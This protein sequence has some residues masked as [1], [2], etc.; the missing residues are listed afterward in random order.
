MDTLSFVDAVPSVA[1]APLS[2]TVSPAALVS[3]LDQSARR[4]ATDDRVV[5]IAFGQVTAG[6]VEIN[7][8]YGLYHKLD[9]ST[10]KM[11][12]HAPAV[13]PQPHV[14]C[15]RCRCRCRCRSERLHSSVSVGGVA[16]VTFLPT[17]AG[18]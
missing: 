6:V 1:S 12:R 13:C 14:V 10:E 3:I 8:T 18:V 9:A 7:H 2:V 11:V 15:M 5:G 17:V 16:C 4:P